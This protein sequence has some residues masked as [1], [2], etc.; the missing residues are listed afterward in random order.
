VV[1]CSSYSISRLAAAAIVLLRVG[2]GIHFLAEGVTKLSEPK[3][4]SGGFLAN[5]KGPLAPLYRGLVWDPDGEY[6]LDDKT[7]FAEWDDYRNRVVS[8]YGFDDKQKKE[9]ERVLKDYEA[10]LKQFLSAN[11]DEIVEYRHWIDRQKANADDPTRQLASLRAHDARIAAETRKLRSQLIP[12]IDILWKDLENDLNALATQQQWE[13]HGRLSIGKPGRGLVD[14][15]TMD[16]IVPWFDTVVGACLILGL[17][18]RPAALLA[19]A[20]LASICAAQWP[21]LSG[22]VPIYNQAVEMLALLAL[23][24][25]GAGRFLGLDFF[26]CGLR[27]ICCPPKKT[28]DMQ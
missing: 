13:Q 28:G 22:A 2:I 3:P 17:F 10:R 5:A 14:S 16:F 18:T 27:A 21:L 24:A 25:I 12:T 4:F 11:R 6:R 20:F 15:E 19:A 1:A 23:A 8:H 26:F 7:T 9:A